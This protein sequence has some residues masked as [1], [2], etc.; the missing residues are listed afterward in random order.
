MP[1]TC[2][3]LAVGSLADWWS[4]SETK[5]HREFTQFLD[6]FGYRD[7]WLLDGY[8]RRLEAGPLVSCGRVDSPGTLTRAFWT[9]GI[10]WPPVGSR[11]PQTATSS[12]YR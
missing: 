5:W 1:V 4:T 10:V 9:F 7:I 8:R 6:T 11:S 2:S 3:I 12:T